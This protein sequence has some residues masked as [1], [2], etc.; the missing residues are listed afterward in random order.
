M[1]AFSVAFDILKGHAKNRKTTYY[2][3]LCKQV[4]GKCGTEFKYHD[5]PTFEE[6]LKEAS[7]KSFREKECLISSLVIT[8]DDNKPSNGFFT[9]A[10]DEF[11]LDIGDRELFF[12]KQLEATFVAYANG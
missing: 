5:D 8:K 7:R 9:Q 4:N 12:I 1:N 2:I 10:K 3:D 11:K 6:V